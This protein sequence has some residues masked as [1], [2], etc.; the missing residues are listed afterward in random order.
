MIAA[1][2][3]YFSMLPFPEALEKVA[4][5][6]RAWEIV[7]E[8]LHRLPDIERQFLE[9]TPS[10][11]LEFSVH[12]PMSDINIGSLSVKMREASMTELRGSM[13]AGRRMG[14]DLFTVHPGFL[15]PLG[16]VAQ[17]KVRETTRSSLEQLDKLS[18]ELGVRIAFEN[19]PKAPTCLASTPQDLAW[20]IEGTD[21]G[22]CWDIGHANTMGLVEEFLELQDRFINMHVHDNMGQ[23]DEHLPVG[24]G[25]V[26]FPKVLKGLRNYRGRYV[27]ESRGFEDGVLGKERLEALL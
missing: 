14:L 6:F 17:Q 23:W 2:S 3:P 16:F 27:V 12:A 1:S 15:T 4:S 11:D 25:T 24:S 8:G 5:K 7:A 9:L 19:M 20:F 22:I 18:R 21:L 26:D 13:E 10:Y